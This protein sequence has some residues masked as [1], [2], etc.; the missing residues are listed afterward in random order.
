VTVLTGGV[1]GARFLRGL[2]ALIDP[3]ALTVIGNT[4]DDDEF[5]GLHV[6][7]DLDTALYTLAGRADRTQGWGIA[8]DTFACLGALSAL[9]G[10]GWFRLGD[11]DLATHIL[12]TRWLRRGVPL[13]VVTA[14]LAR[15]HGLRARLLPM[16]D[17]PVRTIVET[18]AGSLPFQAYLV[19]DR[20]RHRVRG[21]RFRG[22]RHALPAPGVLPAIRRAALVVIAPSNPLVSIGPM[23]SIRR[24]RAAL[25]E[26][27]RPTVAI[28]PLV[29]GRAVRGPLHRMLRGMELAPTPV[30]IA[31]LYR[32]LIDMLVLDRR[33]AAAAPAVAALGIRPIVTET[34]MSTPRRARR[35]AG[36]VLRALDAAPRR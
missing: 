7:P 19:R 27:R 22:A 3:R 33:D 23:L 26:R 20:A 11:R 25:A 32:G 16:T 17:A 2:S 18:A 35:L 5:F 30:T 10:P 8:G 21:I 31:R 28:S 13:S 9:G 15:A 12:R 29:A 14:R 4:A 1:G 24:L 36:A 6:S 34:V